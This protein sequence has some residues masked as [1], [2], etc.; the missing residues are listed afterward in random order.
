MKYKFLENFSNYK[1]YENGQI[2]NIQ[3]EK[4]II[5]SFYKNNNHYCVNIKN[6][7]NLNVKKK[8]G[9]LIYELFIGKLEKEEQ[10]VFI[11]NNNKNFNSS[12]LTKDKFYNIKKKNNFYNENDKNK[13]WKYIKNYDSYQ[14][15]EDGDIYSSASGL[16]KSSIISGYNT[17]RLTKNGKSKR[18][19]AHRLV[20]ETFKNENIDKNNIIDHIDRNKLNNNI[21][22]LREVSRSINSKNIDIKNNIN[23][24]IILQFDKN[25]KLIKEWKD[26]K[27][28]REEL[29]IKC[30]APITACCNGLQ[31]TACGFI[32][33]YK[34]R[35]IHKTEFKEINLPECKLINYKI[36]KDGIII[37]L[38]GQIIQPQINNGYYVSR[39]KIDINKYK[40]FRVHRLV[41]FIF[42][43]N[44][45]N[46]DIVNHIDK[47][48]LNN[49]IK[50]LE[51]ISASGNSKHSH[52]KKVLM[53]DINT[54]ESIKIFE[55]MKDA[56]NYLNKNYYNTSIA[57]VCNGKQKTFNGYK[58]KWYV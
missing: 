16:L 51:W 31:K 53:I 13:I 3:R 43:L 25:N 19:M 58:W 57:D 44:K 34:N 12:N 45:N 22:N 11:D 42:I 37:N 18:F 56:F 32:W 4:F 46:Y 5:P 10:I 28:L 2:Y 15:S 40:T 36:N 26:R 55:S 38:K 30:C 35:I 7:N 14:I 52:G 24:E 50:N 29:K 20:Y 1:I 41:A 23:Y 17:Y 47:N 8:M 48:K 39:L 54:N 21:N 33:K 9:R 6:D 27:L 49:N